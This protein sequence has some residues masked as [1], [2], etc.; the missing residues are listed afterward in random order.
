MLFYFVIF[1]LF[2]RLMEVAEKEDKER[3]RE[4]EIA[5]LKVLI[6]SLQNELATAKTPGQTPRSEMSPKSEVP[7][8]SE[9]EVPVP[10]KSQLSTSE[11]I[12]K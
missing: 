7:A 2:F 12:R 4:A 5:S 10:S 3:E 8:T 1:K 9:S 11:Q 6:K